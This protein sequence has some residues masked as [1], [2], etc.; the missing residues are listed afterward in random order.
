M[1]EL[2]NTIGAGKYKGKKVFL[3]SLDVTR[4]SKAILKGSIFDSI[5]YDIINKVFVEAFAG[6]GSMGLEALSRG[7]KHSY[8]IEKDKHSFKTLA[9][10]CDTIAKGD[11][12]YILGDTFV[13]FPKI[14]KQLAS[15]DKE[16][17]F[18]FDPPFAYRENMEDIYDKSFELIKHITKNQTFLAVFEHM[19]HLTMP[20]SIGE[21]TL[22]KTRKFGK[23]SLSY[24]V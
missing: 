4:S 5:Q 1:A 20:Q 23:S 9:K 10:N 18:Y 19:S 16:V 21:F 6:S 2:Y 7:A 13:E 14:A 12:S 22:V 24:Y 17:I 8:F 15:L 3:P 11:C